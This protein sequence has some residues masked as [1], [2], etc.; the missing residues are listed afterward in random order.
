MICLSTKQK[1]NRS[2]QKMKKVIMVLFLMTVIFG[3]A[4]C[5]GAAEYADPQSPPTE[6]EQDVE[7]VPGDNS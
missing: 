2:N 5:G 7:G 6:T 3:L 1:Q 4:A